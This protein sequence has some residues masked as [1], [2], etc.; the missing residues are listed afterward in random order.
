MSR[1]GI[2]GGVVKPGGGWASLALA[3][4]VFLA[5][6]GALDCGFVRFD[7]HVYVFE[8]PQVAGGLTAAGV[9]W[10]FTTGHASNWH[11]LTWLSHMS[12]VELYGLEPAGH[13]A[14]SV[15]L[16]ALNAILLFLILRTMTGCFGLSWI[17]AALWAVH[18][19]RVESVVWISERKDVLAMFFGLIAVRVY[20][21]AAPGGGTRPTAFRIGPASFFFALSLMSKPLWVTLPF[22]LLLLDFWPLKRWAT[23]PVRRLVGEKWP[24]FLLSAASCIATFAVQRHGGAVGALEVLPLPARVVHAALAYAEYVR[25]LFWPAGLAAFYPYPGADPVDLR[26]VGSVALLAAGTAVAAR[27][28]QGRPWL[29]TGWLWFLGALVPMIGLVQVGAQAWADRYTYLPHVGLILALVWGVAEA[30]EWVGCRPGSP[31]GRVAPGGGTRPTKRFPPIQT[32]LVGALALVL[33]V[34]SRRQSAVWRDT[35]TLFR[36]AIAVTENNALAHGNLGTWYA[37]QGRWPEA[38]PH[39]RRSLALQ[40]SGNKARV[41]LA[42]GLLAAGN[43]PEAL[44]HYLLAVKDVPDLV[45]V[46]NNLAWLLATV[47]GGPPDAGPLAVRHAERAVELTG[48]ANAKVLDTLGAARAA[49]GDFPGAQQAAEQARALAKDD[50]LAREIEKRLALYREGKAFREQ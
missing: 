41:V 33:V 19:L 25:L 40:S 20:G 46:L 28:I 11:P 13:H 31:T 21:G 26:L 1:V 37:E 12:D 15:F 38:E 24:L 50:A 18:P 4:L 9:R 23:E 42:N 10:A 2:Q 32:A 47:P 43:K 17:V 30:M 45:S 27:R 35:E 5:F 14:T 39:L 44:R 34:L 36:H 6:G 7:D 22:L 8:N 3:G 29:V 48:G 16:H 49:A